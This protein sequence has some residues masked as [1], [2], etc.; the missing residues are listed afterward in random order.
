MK[1]WELLGVILAILWSFYTGYVMAVSFGVMGFSWSVR[2]VILHFH[3]GGMTGDVY[4]N[5][6]RFAQWAFVI[7]TVCLLCYIPVALKESK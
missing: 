3:K 4:M 5:L 2:D 6:F 7:L 1:N